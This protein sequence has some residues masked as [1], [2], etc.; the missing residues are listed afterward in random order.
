[1]ETL[2]LQSCSLSDGFGIEL[3]LSLIN[4]PSMKT[5]ILTENNF[6]DVT[7][8]LLCDSARKNKNL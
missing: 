8:S 1:M 3:A 4:C 6:H 5:L 2:D 7:L